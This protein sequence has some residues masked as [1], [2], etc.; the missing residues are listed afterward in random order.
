MPP[1]KN[2]RGRSKQSSPL[3]KAAVSAAASAHCRNAKKPTSSDSRP[4]NPKKKRCGPYKMPPPMPK[5]EILTDFRKNKWCLGTSVG[6]GGFGE[7]Y[8]AC[9]SGCSI[10][11]ARYV[12]KIVSY[13]SMLCR[14]NRVI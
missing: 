4:A 8:T 6:K 10:D 14:Y 1:R 2:L 3:S 7:I 13:G 12:V 11:D 5:G 9:R